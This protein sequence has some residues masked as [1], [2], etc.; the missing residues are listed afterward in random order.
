MR[1]QPYD[2]LFAK[3][4]R[5]GLH[6]FGWFGNGYLRVDEVFNGIRRICRTDPLMDVVK[7]E[8]KTKN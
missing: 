4:G 6:S 3:V 2:E 1:K 8:L 5:P 7:T